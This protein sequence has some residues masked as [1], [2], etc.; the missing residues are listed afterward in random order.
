M[1]KLLFLK[2]YLLSPH[3]LCR[4]LNLTEI[5]SYLARN[6][7][8]LEH[9]TVLNAIRF[10]REIIDFDSRTGKIHDEENAY[11]CELYVV[12]PLTYITLEKEDLTLAKPNILRIFGF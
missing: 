9:D 12:K 2:A 4:L 11:V 7:P 8:R 6:F 5:Q 3:V 10:D 1:A